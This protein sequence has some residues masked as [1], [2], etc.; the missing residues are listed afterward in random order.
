MNDE[1][2]NCPCHG[3]PMYWNNDGRKRAG[4]QWGCVVRKRERACRHYAA[5][6]DK[7][8]AA[9]RNRYQVVADERRAYSL[10]YR[11]ENRDRVNEY[12]RRY[13]RE[14]R[15]AD[16]EKF[17][18]RDREYA[19]TRAHG[20]SRQQRDWLFEQQGGRCAGCLEPFDN[21]ELWVDHDH[22][23]CESTWSCGQCIR[24]LVCPS[25][26]QRDV[27]AGQLWIVFP[28]EEAAS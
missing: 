19:R 1:R 14:A 18:A 22:R 17:R 7:I 8:R 26:N 28:A 9:Q 27:L 13:M 21:A 23:H 3:K 25:C 24:G 4:G 6:A 20:I 15:S 12:D 16:P 11:A 10:K 2:P 5:N